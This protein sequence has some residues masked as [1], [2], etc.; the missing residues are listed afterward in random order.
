[1]YCTHHVQGWAADREEHA[2]QALMKWE[3]GKGP[4]H[5][6]EAHGT[7]VVEG[8]VAGDSLLWWGAGH[9]QVDQSDREM[10]NKDSVQ[11]RPHFRLEM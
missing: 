9:L 3:Q 4:H 6:M 10:L 1:M 2:V 11:D 5:E 8:V 7:V